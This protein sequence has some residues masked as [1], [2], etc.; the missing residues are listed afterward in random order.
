M[1]FSG[2]P[3]YTLCYR[4]TA[5][6]TLAAWQAAVCGHVFHLITF[7]GQSAGQRYTDE[8]WRAR[9]MEEEARGSFL[10]PDVHSSGPPGAHLQSFEPTK[11]NS[12]LTACLR[13]FSSP[14]IL[15]SGQW[16]GRLLP[17]VL[18]LMFPPCVMIGFPT[19]RQT[20]WCGILCVKE[21]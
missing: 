11:G 5:A 16:I 9:R 17:S 20:G 8:T 13:V 15:K 2:L 14:W 10:G 7:P 4:S 12:S 3:W 18:L 19:D 21:I 1:A 6:G